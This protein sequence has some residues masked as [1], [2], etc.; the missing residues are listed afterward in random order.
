MSTTTK[1]NRRTFL[2]ATSA[3]AIGATIVPR[4][5]LGG[6]KYVAPSDK[7]TV[8]YI[9]TGT[10][11]IRVLMSFLRHQDIQVVSVCDVNRDSQ[12]YVEWEKNELRDKVRLFLENPSW[13][14][15]NSGCRA[16]REVGKEIVESYYA[17]KRGKN[18]YNG[19]SAFVDFRELLEKEKDLDAVCIMTPEHTHATIAIAAMKEG[20]HT[21]THKPISNVLSEVR[22]AARVAEESNVATQMFCSANRQTTP[23][24]AEWIWSGAIGQVREVHNWTK[25][26]FW[27][28]GMTE[29]PGETPPIPD[30]FN[31][32][33]WLGP[34]E[35]RPY[36][37]AYTHAAFRGWYDFGTGPLGD[38]GHYSFYQIWQILKLASPISVEASRSEYWAIDK[39]YWEKHV[40]TVSFP[41]AAIVHWEFPERGNMA[42]VTLHWYDGGLKPPI[43]KELETDNRAMPEEG[44]LF[45]GDKG[46]ILADFAGDSPR[47][48]PE[49]KMSS[50]HR[51]PKSL[52]RPIDE[53][54]QW[55]RACKGG[56]P[57]DARF[58]VVRPINEPI[59]LGTIALRTDKKLYWD[60]DHAKFTNSPEANELLYRKY[61]PGWELPV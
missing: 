48:I 15:G 22:L 51:P 43:P 52:P 50:F 16:G 53:L 34:A 26:P 47:L 35:Y 58:E 29:C 3:A 4:H 13:G 6:Q 32:D 18:D 30:G 41:R 59:C 57:A 8:G 31:W 19:C 7:I 27:P 46:K 12:D 60:A 24:L 5:V 2:G 42:P 55:V 1:I 20:K 17:Q 23:L 38:M 61:R 11:G 36:H 28:Q 44:L 14:E 54:E 49:E 37:P 33:L 10:Q 56:E 39:G 45:V 25:R 40:N 21:I 9:G